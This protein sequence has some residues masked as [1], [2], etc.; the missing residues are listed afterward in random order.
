LNTGHILLTTARIAFGIMF[1]LL[2]LAGGH[3]R[4]KQR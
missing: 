1:G 3:W 2:A 4:D